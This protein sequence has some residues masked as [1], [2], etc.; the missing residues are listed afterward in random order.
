[1]KVIK[2]HKNSKFTVKNINDL[3]ENSNKHTNEVRKSIQDQDKKVSHMDKKFNKE[4]E[5][6]EKN[7]ANKKFNKSNNNHSGEH[8]Q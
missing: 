4:I 7:V 2:Y 6:L 3:K 1:M 5:I 8:H